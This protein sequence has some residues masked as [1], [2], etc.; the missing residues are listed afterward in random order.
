MQ[1]IGASAAPGATCRGCS[2]RRGRG[3]ARL[4]DCSTSNG[5]RDAALFE[6]MY[7]TGSRASETVAMDRGDLDLQRPGAHLRQG[8]YETPAVLG[9]YA[10]PPSSTS[11]TRRAPKPCARPATPCSWAAGARASS[12]AASSASSRSMPRPAGIPRRV[13][14]HTLRHSFATHLLDRGADLRAVL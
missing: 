13:T 11:P 2:P 14:P 9:R 12:P 8:P 6:I 5:L 10:Q 7:S 3:P 4:P 1:L